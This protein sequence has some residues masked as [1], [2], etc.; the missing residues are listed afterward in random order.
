MM[1]K[2]RLNTEEILDPRLYGSTSTA[3]CVAS[4]MASHLQRCIDTYIFGFGPHTG[5][6]HVN[7]AWRF[8]QSIASAAKGNEVNGNI[9]HAS[10]I[11]AVR[12]Y[13]CFLV[14]KEFDLNLQYYR[15]S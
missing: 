5:E 11:S 13:V 4:Y 6:T 3:N 8:I 10:V 9:L 2:Y 7:G 15:Q 1:F 12:S 14:A